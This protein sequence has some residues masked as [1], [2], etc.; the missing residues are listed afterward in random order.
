MPE[1]D[2]WLAVPTLVAVASY[3]ASAAGE[4][5]GFFPE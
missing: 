1:Y 4:R 5:S 2:P 3:A